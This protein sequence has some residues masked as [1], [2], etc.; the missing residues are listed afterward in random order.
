MGQ[1]I[2][3]NIAKIVILF[4]IWRILLFLIAFIS[5]AVI[6]Q[7][8]ARFPY[9]QER[10]IASGLPHFIWSFGNFDGVHY[11]GIAKDAYAYQYTQVFF[12]LYPL[13]IRLVSLLTFGNLLIAGLLISN[14]AFFVSL[15]IFYKLVNKYHGE[16]IAFWSCL[17]LLSF[18]T[19]FYFGA[20]YT[21][22]IF[23]LLIISVFYLF[24]KKKILLA[25]I[26]GSFASATRLVGLFLIPAISLKKNIQSII[27]ILIAP[28]GFLAYVLYL[29]IEFNNPL[30]FV[31]AQTIF[32][33]ERSTTQIILLPQVFWRYLKI[34]ATTN[35]LTFAN[36]AFELGI[37]ISILTLLVLSYRRVKTEWL[38]FSF[39]AVLMPT[40]TGTLASMPRYVLIAFP[41]YILLASIKSL[42]IKILIVIVFSVLLIITTVLFTQG[43]WVA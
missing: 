12:P 29:K 42:I 33:Q 35:G 19:S 39:L 21:E 2:K 18:P 36:A 26:L 24:Y 17:F 28:L 4:V 43:Y 6:P 15:V 9:Y 37:T 30:Y 20:I 31:S 13:L 23:F 7:F 41:V 40:F 38:I 3:S 16:K 25:S 22:G 11:L 8:G 32:G 14:I 34:L 5:P 27:P 10:L 1:L